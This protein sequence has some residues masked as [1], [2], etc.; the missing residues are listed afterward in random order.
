M[1]VWLSVALRMQF[2]FSACIYVSLYKREIL[3]IL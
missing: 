1:A 2:D 3:L